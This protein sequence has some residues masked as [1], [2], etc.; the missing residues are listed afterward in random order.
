MFHGILVVV[1]KTAVRGRLAIPMVVAY[2]TRRHLT[3]GGSHG[4]PW[5]RT[6]DLPDRR[7]SWSWHRDHLRR[8]R[9]T[10]ARSLGRHPFEV[11]QAR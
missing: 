8:D 11:L 5:S 6:T 3:K 7:G 1:D 2:L 4:A 9:G 10:A